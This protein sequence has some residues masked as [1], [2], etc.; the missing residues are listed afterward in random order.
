[1]N[2]LQLVNRLRRECK[3]SGWSTA[4]TTLVGVT[5]ESEDLAGLVSQADIEICQLHADWQFLRTAFS[6]DTVANDGDYLPSAAPVSLADFGSLCRDSLRIYSTAQGVSGMRHLC[7]WD[8]ANFRDVWLFGS[9][10]TTY[11]PPVAVSQKPDK[12]ILLGPAPDGI[13]TV[14]G[15]YFKVATE[16]S[17]DADTPLYPER[18]HMLCVWKA[19]MEYGASEAASE[20][21]QRGANNYRSM[22]ANL[23][24]DQL[25]EMTFAEPL[26]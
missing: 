23:R 3:V 4:L 5:G 20:T 12:T 1:M 6:F 24:Q 13:Y 10:I 15:D 2:R 18:F 11:G 14:A 26:A 19:M 17:D 25:P 8:Y 7:W 21:Y 16:L 22:L 9:Q